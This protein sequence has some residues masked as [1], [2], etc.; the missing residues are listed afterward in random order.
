M[1]GPL[2]NKHD[3]PTAPARGFTLIELMVVVALIGALVMLSGPSF[4][5]FIDT[6][7]LRSV[8]SALI[9][10]LQ[11]ARSEAASRNTFMRIKF[12]GTGSSMTCYTIMVGDAAFCDCTRTPGVDVCRGP[13]QTE[14]RTVQ[15]PRSTGIALSLPEYAAAQS[16][17]FDPATGRL[18][19]FVG[20][21][22][23]PPGGPFLIDVSNTDIG[24]FRDSVLATGR[25]SACSPSGSLSGVT[26]CAP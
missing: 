6:Q 25:P 3:H 19:V 7:R 2:M 8:N 18:S 23:N 24:G 12:D 4:K 21:E 13:A 5:R 16:I 20:D 9:T 15:I 22:Y 26:P 10:D 17:Q 11:F 1:L 14:I